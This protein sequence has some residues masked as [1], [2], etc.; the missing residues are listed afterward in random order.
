MT[1]R[2]SRKSIPSSLASSAHSKRR[3]KIKR[4]NLLLE[5]LEDRRVMA[6]GPDLASI[7]PTTGSLLTAGAILRV[8]PRDL[9]FKFSNEVPQKLDPASLSTAFAP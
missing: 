8:S 3:E 5:N 2:R 9:T 1:I 6:A 7:Q 4:R